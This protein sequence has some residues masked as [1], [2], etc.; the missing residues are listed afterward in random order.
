MI[1]IDT[2]A[3]FALADEKDQKNSE[4]VVKL[5]SF[6]SDQ[7]EL[8]THNYILSETFALM[9]RRLGFESVRAFYRDVHRMCRVLWV[10][11]SQHERSAKSFVQQ[12]SPKFSFVDCV[13]FEIMKANG[14]RHYFAFDDDFQR[15]GFQPAG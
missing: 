3:F 4:A 9:S 6:L 15:A 2:S 14:I 10:S 12:S 8:V 11:Q 5:E 7:K 13:S 1:F